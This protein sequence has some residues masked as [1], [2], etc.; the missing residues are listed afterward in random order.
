MT[1]LKLNK[2]TI[3]AL[4]ALLVSCQTAPKKPSA[5]GA[6]QPQPQQPRQD[7]T[8][9]RPSAP[10]RGQDAV[11]NALEDALKEESV[12]KTRRQLNR[13]KVDELNRQQLYRYRVAVIESYRISGRSKQAKSAI[14]NSRLD[15]LGGIPLGQQLNFYLTYARVLEDDGDIRTALRILILADERLSA[16]DSREN[17]KQIVRLLE[18]LS[19]EDLLREARLAPDLYMRGW[20]DFGLLRHID[21]TYGRADA[22]AL[23]RSQYTSHPG[24]RYLSFINTRQAQIIEVAA[25]A[26]KKNIKVSFLLPFGDKALGVISNSIVDGY[27][28]MA[29]RYGIRVSSQNLDTANAGAS[30]ADLYSRAVSDGSDIVVGPLRKDQVQE[31]YGAVGNLRVPVIALNDA[32]DRYRKKENF[33]TLS[34]NFEKN[35]EFAANAAWD[36]QCRNIAIMTQAESLLAERGQ[37]AFRNEWA[38]LGGN[39]VVSQTLTKEKKL[40]EWVSG[41]LQVSSSEVDANK[42]VFSSY[43]TKFSQLGLS[44]QQISTLLRGGQQ[45][46]GTP[47]TLPFPDKTFLVS[48]AEIE[49]LQNEYYNRQPIW[50]ENSLR[51]QLY[52]GLAL[53][54]VP[55]DADYTKDD[56]ESLMLEFSRAVRNSYSRANIECIFLAMDSGGLARV[57]PYISF[58][59]ANDIPLFSTFLAYDR[60]TRSSEYTDLEGITYGEFPG[61]LND[62]KE[63]ANDKVFLKR[64]YLTGRDALS[65]TQTLPQLSQ[66]PATANRN[67][68]GGNADFTYSVLGEAGLLYMD[69]NQIYNIPREVTFSGGTPK[70]Q[71][72]LSIFQ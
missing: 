34:S 55:A 54:E 57:R 19:M 18:K 68:R 44:Q 1:Q 26:N 32:G 10:A 72:R 61:V 67:T 11:L 53:L 8:D 14:A 51:G 46:S 50:Q 24:N 6:Q 69:N 38:K 48:V 23:W 71:T 16:Q 65:L 20:Y 25:P 63:L 22:Q 12:S 4:F 41:I 43:L 28:E 7:Q 31:L 40:T 9:T 47:N 52:T 36:H 35:V 64:F 59:L 33:Y 58:Y 62:H 42:K 21:N 13:V 3:I 56:I 39:V 37:R 29:S 60:G 30:M 17:Q 5:S 49:M 2:I 27:K 45:N 66:F 70:R 15:F